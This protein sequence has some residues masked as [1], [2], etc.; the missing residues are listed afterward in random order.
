MKQLRTHRE[1]LGISQSRLA[2][3]AGVSR[4]KICLFEIGDGK[5]TEDE[6]TKIRAA[7]N[8][9]IQRLQRLSATVDLARMSAPEAAEKGRI[10]GKNKKGKDAFF[11]T[12]RVAEAGSVGS[13]LLKSARVFF[14]ILDHRYRDV[15]E[16]P[17]DS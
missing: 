10:G 15:C 12:V 3:P 5:L 7:L 9:E 8:G 4:F 11:E 14:D 17:I 2:R 16:G 6:L 1:A 13:H